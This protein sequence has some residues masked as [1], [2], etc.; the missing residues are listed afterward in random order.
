VG[1]YGKFL[2]Y[3]QKHGHKGLKCCTAEILD[4]RPVGWEMQKGS[5]RLPV[6]GVSIEDAK[7]YASWRGKILPTRAQWELAATR[8]KGSKCLKY[9]YGDI[10]DPSLVNG[11]GD[12]PDAAS[13]VPVDDQRFLPGASACG[14]LHFS[15]NAAEWVE[16]ASGAAFLMG[17]SCKTGEPE[18]LRADFG[19]PA[20]TG[21]GGMDL[22]IL[23]VAGFRCALRAIS[24][25]AK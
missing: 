6:V 22:S 10:F 20:G 3:L 11:G 16:E 21:D 19:F 7:A 12:L 5:P 1:E 18:Y 25:E 24:T 23:E 2:A 14:C 13:L 4:H 17:G 9:P 15:G 8:G